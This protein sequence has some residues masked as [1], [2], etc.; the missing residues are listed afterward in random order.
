MSKDTIYRQDAID[1]L[2]NE[3][4]LWED[5]YSLSEE[6][7]KGQREQWNNDREILLNLPPADV[8]PDIKEL[9]ID[10]KN[11]ISA[12]NT[13]DIYCCG[14]RNG[15]RWVL[16]LI[17]G[18]EPSFESARNAADAQPV[19][20]CSECEHWNDGT[21]NC[22]DYEI[23]CQ[24]YYVGDMHTDPDFFCGFGKRKGADE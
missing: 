17:D 13:N 18:K 3:P 21:C 2:G 8:Q 1:A 5:P 24:D 10:I 16:S 14:M 22:D 6:Y 20:R 19:V 15:M 7:S 9:I 12:T 4:K 11:G 23:H